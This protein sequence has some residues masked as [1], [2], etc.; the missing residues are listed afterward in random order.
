V[1]TRRL[2]RGVRGDR[3]LITSAAHMPRAVACF[4]HL[5]MAVV[6][7][8]VDYLRTGSGPGA[9]LPKP[10]TLERS[11]TALHEY[12]GWLAYWLMGYV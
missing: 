2:L 6:P 12:L 11:A 5:G 4:R 8:P 3:L 10:R 9:W 7:W 1:N